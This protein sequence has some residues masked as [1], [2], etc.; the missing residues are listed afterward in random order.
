MK[1]EAAAMVLLGSLGGEREREIEDRKREGC[2]ELQLL[3]RGGRKG[4]REGGTGWG[5]RGLG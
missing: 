2:G 1:G 5:F 3:G 4:S